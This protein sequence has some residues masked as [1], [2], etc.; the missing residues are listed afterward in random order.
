VAD[1]RKQA[2]MS[3]STE[4]WAPIPGYEGLYEAS[5]L[6]RIWSIHRPG[7]GKTGRILKQPLNASRYPFVNLSKGGKTWPWTVHR[8]VMLAFAG[9]PPPGQEVRH[10]DGNRANPALSNL[11]YGTRSENVRDTLRH[12]TNY[13]ANKTHCKYGH[14][15][16]PQ[17]T[18][19]NSKG[20]RECRTC[21]MRRD[22]ERARR[23]ATKTK[24]A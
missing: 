18:Y 20:S 21:M 17:N 22:R 3:D 4:R 16:T 8:L 14:E 1:L 10:K 11:E 9:P 23:S 2:D 12:G 15:F 19:V 6:G 13:W 7:V 24:R 5:T